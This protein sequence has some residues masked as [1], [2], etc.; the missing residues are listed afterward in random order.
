MDARCHVQRPNRAGVGA[1]LVGARNRMPLEGGRP[2]RSPLRMDTKSD[3]PYRRSIRWRE[4]DYS[5]PGAY[6][7]TIRIQD[8]QC[9]LGD[10]VDGQMQLNDAGRMVDAAWREIPI[11]FPA[12]RLDEHVIMP[13]HMHGII[14]IGHPQGVPLRSGRPRGSRRRWGLSSARLSP[15]PLESIYS[16]LSMMDCRGSR[17]PSGKETIMSYVIRNQDELGKIGEYIRLNPLL[18]TTDRYNLEQT[19]LVVDETGRAVPWDQS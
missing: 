3:L 13:N 18:W 5:W 12:A 1:P 9:L 17:N 7:V 19:V 11:R 16:V 2:P 8:Q 15:S 4:Y 14:H 10:V 6:Y